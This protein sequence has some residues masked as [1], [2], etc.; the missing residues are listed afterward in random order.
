MK[1][2]LK[3][4]IFTH[5]GAKAVKIS[6]ELQ[7]RRSVMSCLL[8]EDEFYEDG[9]SIAQRIVETIPS[10]EA[11]IVAS[12]AIE[13]RTKMK[14]RHVPLLIVREM[15]RLQSHRALVAETLYQIIQ[16]ADEL[17]EFVA[18]YWKEGKQPLSAQVKNGLARA[19]TKFDAYQLA[20]YNRDEVIK[21]RDVLFLC[22]AKPIDKAQEEIWKKLV[23]GT[24]ESPDTWEVSLSAGKDKK[25]SFEHLLKENKLGSLA[26][27]RNLRNM[28][29]AKVDESLVFSALEKMKVE[30]VL[31]YRFITAARYAPQWED[32]IE[33]A[34]MK[35]LESLE[36]I[37]G[38]TVILADVSGSMDTKITRSEINRIDV[39]CGLAVLTREICN[40]EVYTFSNDVKQIPARH[41]FALRDSILNSQPHGNTYL[42]KAV[43]FININVPCDRLIVVTDEQSHDNVPSPKTKGY[44]INVASNQNGVGYGQWTH[45]DGF[46]EAVLEYIKQKE[47]F[48]ISVQPNQEQV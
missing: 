20:K 41:G 4:R 25:E 28:A 48:D 43:D 29:E 12:I 15:A 19:F 39:A 1:L 3:P 14:L 5:E 47:M 37:E 11:S 13:A 36:K 27:L 38:K 30:R 17:A 46:S 22:H 24:M 40:A 23:D 8:W 34:M 2:N 16:R 18:L 21:L 31:P 42:G 35:C 32:K 45:I 6:P 10:V 7:L 26:L 44:L 33:I 9:V